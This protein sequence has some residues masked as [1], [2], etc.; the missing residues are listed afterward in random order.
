MTEDL[1][2]DDCFLLVYSVVG[3]K[4]CDGKDENWQANSMIFCTSQ[5]CSRR[6]IR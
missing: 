6:A 2:S 5:H 4:G 3:G 1:C